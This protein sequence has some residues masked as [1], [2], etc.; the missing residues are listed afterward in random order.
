MPV[1]ATEQTAEDGDTSA[2]H[3]YDVIPSVTRCWSKRPVSRMSV[4]MQNSKFSRKT[5]IIKKIFILEMIVRIRCLVKLA[6]FRL[7]KMQH[8]PSSIKLIKRIG[9]GDY[10]LLLLVTKSRHK[11]SPVV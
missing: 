5:I 7:A 9:A 4:T 2:L 8:W 6:G 11:H 1:T 3:T 10:L